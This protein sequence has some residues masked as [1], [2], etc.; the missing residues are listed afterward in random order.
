MA[1]NDTMAR[2]ATAGNFRS[3]PA[4]QREH[5]RAGYSTLPLSIGTKYVKFDFMQRQAEVHVND[6]AD[7]RLAIDVGSSMNT[8]LRAWIGTARKST[9]FFVCLEDHHMCTKTRCYSAVAKS[10]SDGV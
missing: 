5:D 2:K 6:A 10:A 1:F 8:A 4:G 3:A 7:L 9:S